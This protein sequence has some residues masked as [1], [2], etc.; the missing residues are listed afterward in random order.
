[1][2]IGILF[3]LLGVLYVNSES[4]F[5]YV[6]GRVDYLGIDSTGD[7]V[8][9]RS[10]IANLFPQDIFGGGNDCVVYKFDNLL[11]HIVAGVF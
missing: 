6:F 7:V 8:C 5:G 4:Y 9:I 11:V 2:H 1:M 10:L 3:I